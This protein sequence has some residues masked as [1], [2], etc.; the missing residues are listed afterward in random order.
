MKFNVGDKA[1]HPAHGVGEVTSIEK[2]KI[3]GTDKSFYIMKIVDSG[4]TVMVPI[5]G[6]ERRDVGKQPLPAGAWTWICPE[7]G[8]F[9]LSAVMRPHEA[10]FAFLLQERKRKKNKPGLPLW[11]PLSVTGELVI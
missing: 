8:T 7:L 4:M 2:K 3:A 10:G 9:D 6:V 1:V 5:D 11:C